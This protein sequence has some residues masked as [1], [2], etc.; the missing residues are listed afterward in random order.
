MFACWGTVAHRFRSTSLIL[1]LLTAVA[2]GVWGLGVFDRLGQGGYDDPAS[3]AA[4]ADE[5]GD[6]ALDA[7][8]ADVMVLY[9]APPGRTVDDPDMASKINVK[10]EALPRTEVGAVTSYWRTPVPDLAGQ[11]KRVGLAVIGLAGDDPNAKLRSYEQISGELQVAGVPTQVAGEMPMQASLQERAKRDL[12]LAEAVSMPI[13]LVL[14]VLIFGGVVAAS[15]P[16]LVGG[17]AV[18]GSLGLLHLISLFTSVNVFAVNVASLLGLGL[19]I[20]Y[21]LFIVGRYREEL[22]QG[23]RGVEAVRRTVASAGRTVVFSSTLLI[24]ALAGLLLFPQGF[25]R[26]LA[27]GGMSAVALAATI[28]LTLLPALLGLLEHRVDALALPWHRKATEG[29]SEGRGFR[30]LADKVMKRPLLTAVPIV[31]A[32]VILGAPFLHGRF[33]TPNEVM[34]PS[35][36]PAR[37]AVES[38]KRDFPAMSDKDVRI[39][40]RGQGEAPPSPKDVERF[41]SEG[42]EIRGM[43]ELRPAGARGAVVVFNATLE[44]DTYSDRSARAVQDLRGLTPPPGTEVLVGGPTAENLDSLRATSQ[45]LPWMALLIVGATLVLMFLAFGS[46]LLPIKAVVVSAL[47]LSA[48]FGVLT[49]VFVDGHGAGPL[50]ITPSP[51]EDGVLVLM[52]SIVF[53]LSTDY[54][55]FLLSRMVEARAGGASTAEAVRTG[56][57]RTG[58]MI[59]AAALLLIVVTG[60]FATSGIL[61]MRFIGVGMVLALALD[62]TVVRMVLVPAL[63]RLLGDAAWWAPRPL[64]RSQAQVPIDEA[65]PAEDADEATRLTEPVE[66]SAEI[67]G[68]IAPVPHPAETTL[69]IA[70]APRPIRRVAPAPR[71]AETTRP[72]TSVR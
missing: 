51:M 54:E 66:C 27:Y 19:A 53:G 64:R 61:M 37:Q 35:G 44:H 2:G 49:G 67:T 26:S 68:P 3:E 57:G 12:A 4:R 41:Q 31:V 21:G 18:F 30:Q 22:G 46:V 40:L 65:G 7:A 70:P 28:S 59:S 25:L 11:D 14:L 39:V 16:V 33:G 9:T 29:T 43:Q 47:S 24:I 32:L 15:L 56:L 58:R 20:D 36:D 23:R 62:A 17:L 34:L 48:T 6:A 63:L 52:A 8:D 45:R 55:A 5:I 72:S 13:V 71:P 69:P 38:L 60:A 10:L 50:G 1:V 42:T